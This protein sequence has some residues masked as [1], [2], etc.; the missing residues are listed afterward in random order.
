MRGGGAERGEHGFMPWMRKMD[1]AL[2]VPRYPLTCGNRGLSFTLALFPGPLCLLPRLTGPKM[3]HWHGLYTTC[4]RRPIR[5]I[6]L[7]NL[8]L[9]KK[10]RLS[11]TL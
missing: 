8:Q 6:K 5:T 3:G 4:S 1:K 9:L 10:K 11:P 2:A 7:D